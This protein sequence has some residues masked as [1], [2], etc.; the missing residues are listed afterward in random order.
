MLSIDVEGLV[1]EAPLCSPPLTPV[2][3]QALAYSD[4][5]LWMAQLDE[6]MRRTRRVLQAVAAPSIV[7]VPPVPEAGPSIPAD[8]VPDEGTTTTA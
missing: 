6:T 5:E 7:P 2:E 3:R 4:L 8:D 1:I